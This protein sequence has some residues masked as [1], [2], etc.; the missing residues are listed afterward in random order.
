MS[1]Q[2]LNWAWR[3]HRSSPTQKLVLMALADHANSDGDCHPS[4]D[5]IAELADCS[6]R[7]ARRHVE[8]L[9]SAGLV[10]KTSRH[11]RKDG[12][13]GVW[14]LELAMKDESDDPTE[15]HRSHVTGGPAATDGQWP[16]PAS[17]HECHS[18]A[19]TAVSALNQ[20]LEPSSPTGKE[21]DASEPAMLPLGESANGKDQPEPASDDRLLSMAGQWL[22]ERHGVDVGEKPNVYSIYD[23]VLRATLTRVPDKKQHPTAMGL[24]CEFW[25]RTRGEVLTQS[26][27]SRVGKLLKGHQPTIVLR[28]VSESVDW[29]AGDSEEYA[30]DEKASVNYVTRV[31]QELEK[32]GAAS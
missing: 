5:T 7:T 17:G 30:D 14:H 20:D 23:A 18:P 13:L 29:G 26:E 25:Q 22:R 3:I 32:Q 11:R 1:I 19:A 28:A 4:F 6:P 10:R 15:H 8:E 21:A 31:V 24:V 27:R 12:T 16:N 2:A 9:V